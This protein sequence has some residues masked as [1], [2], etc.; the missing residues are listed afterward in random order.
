MNILSVRLLPS[1]PHIHILNLKPIDFVLAFPQADIDIDIL[2]E[3]PEGMTP[4]GDE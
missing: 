1:I 4:V 3:L 2:M